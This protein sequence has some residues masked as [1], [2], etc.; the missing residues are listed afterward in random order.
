[1]TFTHYNNGAKHNLADEVDDV[2]EGGREDR[3]G[4]SVADQHVADLGHAPR[5]RYVA[6]QQSKISGSDCVNRVHATLQRTAVKSEEK[7]ACSR[8]ENTVRG[9][10]NSCRGSRMWRRVAAHSLRPEETEE[11]ASLAVDD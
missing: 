3:I 1:M 8:P 5:A 7:N 6:L 4:E 9:T 10:S 11:D 2:S